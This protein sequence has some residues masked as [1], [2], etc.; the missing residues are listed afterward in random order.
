MDVHGY[1]N[2]YVVQ[3]RR[4]EGRERRGGIGTSGENEGRGAA[5]A[6]EKLN[7]HKHRVPYAVVWIHEGVRYGKQG[8]A[9]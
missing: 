5:G 7:Q 6:R 4:E 3:P 9:T 8:K 1:A 2:S